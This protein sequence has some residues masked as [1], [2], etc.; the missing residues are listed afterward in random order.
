MQRGEHRSKLGEASVLNPV[1]VLINVARG[2]HRSK[3][4]Q[5]LADG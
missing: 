5:A 3:L 1:A 4:G 2:E